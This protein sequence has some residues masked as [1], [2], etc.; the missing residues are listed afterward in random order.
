MPWEREKNCAAVKSCRSRE[1]VARE[2][3]SSSLDVVPLRAAQVV[4]PFPKSEPVS[5]A[6]ASGR[7]VLG[8]ARFKM[9]RGRPAPDESSSGPLRLSAQM[10]DARSPS[11]RAW[12]CGRPAPG[13]SPV[14][15]CRNTVL[16]HCRAPPKPGREGAP[17]GPSAAAILFAAVVAGVE[18]PRSL[19]ESEIPTEWAMFALSPAPDSGATPM[20][21][22]KTVVAGGE[23]TPWGCAPVP[24]APA[25]GGNPPAPAPGERV[26]STRPPSSCPSSASARKRQ[27]AASSGHPFAARVV[28]SRRN[29]DRLIGPSG[30]CYLLIDRGQRRKSAVCPRSPFE[31]SIVASA[32]PSPPVTHT[33]G[34]REG[35]GRRPADWGRID[36][37]G[38][39]ARLSLQ[40]NPKRAIAVGSV[41]VPRNS[42]HH[43][44][45][46]VEALLRRRRSTPADAHGA[47]R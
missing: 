47:E 20:P 1:P 39:W 3:L 46:V 34:D 36:P 5:T 22:P 30:S 29:E 31:E 7:P 40:L 26:P 17:P 43:S 19:S 12:E 23:T 25:H 2:A 16:V 24:V 42:V 14:P 41:V 15:P 18:T 8:T 33:A 13:Q 44:V 35:L 11:P 32:A 28:G 6:I 27:I 4:K 45:S 21:P 37:R 38:G 9:R 10:D